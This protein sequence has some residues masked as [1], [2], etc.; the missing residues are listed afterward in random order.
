MKLL[1]LSL[2]S[3]SSRINR[4]VRFIT[5]K[6]TAHRVVRVVPCSLAFA[7]ILEGGRR[8]M[9][10][11]VASGKVAPQQ[12]QFGSSFNSKPRRDEQ[13]R[14]VWSRFFAFVY[15]VHPGK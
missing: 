1:I 14:A 10:L 3:P 6:Q 2:F 9:I 12:V 7:R 13:L 4:F 5:L 11:S 15:R 8:A